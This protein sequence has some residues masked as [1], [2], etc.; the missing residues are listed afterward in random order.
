MRC[1][2]YFFLCFL[3]RSFLFKFFFFWILS[4]VFW[5]VLLLLGGSGLKRI[6][7]LEVLEEFEFLDF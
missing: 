1:I 4:D 6:V 3:D 2:Y 5:F 7:Y